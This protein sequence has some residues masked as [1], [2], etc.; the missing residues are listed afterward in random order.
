MIDSSQSSDADIRTPDC[1]SAPRARVSRS[2]LDCGELQRL[3][4]RADSQLRALGGASILIT[5]ST[6]WFGV[7]LLDVLCLADDM[8]RLGI[9]I[10]AVS[11]EPERFLARFPAFAG[12]S[13]ITWIQA[14]V[15]RLEPVDGGFSHVIHAAT[16]TSAKP[17]PDA[18]R[19]LFETIVEGTR[20]VIAAAG[21]RCK[22]VLLLSSGAI[23]GPPRVDQARFIE[24]E[25]GGPDPALTRNAYAE[26]KRTAEQLGAIAAA[27]GIPVRIARCFAFVGPH[28]PFDRHFAIGNFIA[29]AVHGR[30]IRIKSDGR[31]Q[32]SYLYMTDLI[33]ALLAIL[34]DGAAGRPYNVGSDAPVTIEQLA[35][36]V[37]R[38]AGGHG[39]S[40]EGAPSDPL[41]R[42]V[43][44]ITRLK[45]ELGF[46]P[47]VSLESAVSRTAA[48][49]RA[50][51]NESM[52]S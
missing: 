29:D 46:A 39:V 44:D 31:P 47:E 22:A 49:Y 23:Y 50:R 24:S 42:Y 48:W 4:R 52:T 32:R 16:D 14:D 27:M 20:R 13:R 10:A 6:G 9:R 34:V 26:G 36:C 5:G 2:G 11:R 28:M 12:D 41:D 25:A 7:W 17:D 43:P 19:D 18:T 40:I 15:R 45:Q 35:R 3:L 51:I 30:P 1:E 21:P 38:V 33:H 37:D 8:L